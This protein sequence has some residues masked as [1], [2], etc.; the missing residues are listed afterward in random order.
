MLKNSPQINYPF[1]LNQKQEEIS[2]NSLKIQHPWHIYCVIKSEF[3]CIVKLDKKIHIICAD[4]FLS[5][6][7]QKKLEL[8]GFSVSFSDESDL[9]EEKIIN[10]KD[11]IDCFIIDS[12]MDEYLFIKLKMRFK[13]SSYI[14]LPSIEKTEKSEKITGIENISEPLRLSELFQTLDSVFKKK[15]IGI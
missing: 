12:G 9:T 14:F 2:K 10:L 8:Q 13:N 15:D 4:K 3:K 11:D 5:I 6:L 7:I 1:V